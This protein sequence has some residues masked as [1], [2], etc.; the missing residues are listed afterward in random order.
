MRTPTST[1]AHGLDLL[2]ARVREERAR[3]REKWQR[4]FTRRRFL[5]GAGMAGAAALGTQLVTTRFA[6][7]VPGTTDGRAL[8]V[9]FLRGGFDG[10]AAV[11][12]AGDPD[13]V[14]A[15]PQIGVPERLL[16]PLDRGFGLHPA[17]APLHPYW[18]QGRL[19]VV[20][21]VGGPDI[22]RSHFQAQDQ[23]ERGVE[24]AVART[25][26]LERALAAAGPGT[27]F[28]ATA[29][30]VSAPLSLAGTPG[31]VSLRG[32]G[33]VEL[34]R[35]SE[36]T[37]TALAELYTG[38]DLLAAQ[39][40]PLALTLLA[41]ATRL[42]A[43]PYQPAVRYPDGPFGAA[44]ADVAR[45]LK[46]GTGLR[47]A[48]VDVGG[49]DIH[50]GAGTAEAGDMTDHLDGLGRALAA[51]GTDLGD[52]LDDVTV[53]AMSEFGRRVAQNGSGG[54]DHGR[55]NA[56]L[57]LG[58]PVVGG[59]HGAWP[60]LGPAELA[61]GDLAVTTDYR[62]VLYEL[63]RSQLGVGSVDAVF[64]GLAHTPLGVMRGV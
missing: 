41:E 43:Q 4:G 13:Y 3:E 64:P 16:L 20:H 23:V 17:L 55:G 12:P 15:R 1:G 32:L 50:T 19:A 59:V 58:G 45:L 49:W 14:A 24:S 31:A 61:D 62:D 8:V 18:T 36:R 33:S 35:D 26:W 9:V 39:Q 57:V 53:V 7:A 30:G 54:T 40:V 2:A 48:T 51:F 22:T 63:A 38:L 44:L 10:L 6:Y 47:V 27:T 56:M 37:R 34:Y 21:A 11:V 42:G 60:G 29:E 46:S 5:A 25:G 52:G 28:R